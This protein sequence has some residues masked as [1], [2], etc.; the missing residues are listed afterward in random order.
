VRS[1]RALPHSASES[2]L[3][4]AYASRLISSL[5][6]YDIGGSRDS[7]QLYT[8][9]GELEG[10]LERLT[11]RAT[12]GLCS[13]GRLSVDKKTV[14]VVDDNP[15]VIAILTRGLKEEGFGIVS[16]S[17]AEQVPPPAFALLSA[18]SISL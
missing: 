7:H 16:R 5:S 8:K 15:I 13:G 12:A 10:L 3:V 6:P 1:G 18:R 14:M 4:D 17:S 9:A 11:T 2:R